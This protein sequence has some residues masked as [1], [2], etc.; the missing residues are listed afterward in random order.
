MKRSNVANDK[1][2][3]L[4]KIDTEEFRAITAYRVVLG[5]V[6]IGYVFKTRDNSY[7]GTQG[8]N[9]GIRITDY[10]PL[11]WKIQTSKKSKP[12]LCSNRASGVEKLLIYSREL[13]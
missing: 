2:V 4:T 11:R 7:M 1:S 9:R 8:W 13:I 10:N 12:E 5:G 3:K 6:K